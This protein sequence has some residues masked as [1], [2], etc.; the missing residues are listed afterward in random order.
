MDFEQIADKIEPVWNWW[1]GLFADVPEYP[2]AVTVY[3]GGSLLVLWL[4]SI[5]ARAMPRTIGEM[6]WVLLLS[7]LATPTVTEGPN[8]QIAPAVVGLMFGVITKDV[9]LILHSALPMLFVFG[10]GCLVC[11]VL[12]R[13]H[14]HTSP[15]DQV[16]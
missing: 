6:S 8:G 11:F 4:W 16:E 15:Q 12:E 3:V 2:L 14:G 5:V 9:P 1:T 10:I 7:I 13:M